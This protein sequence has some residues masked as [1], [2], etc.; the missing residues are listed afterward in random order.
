MTT[1]IIITA[2]VITTLWLLVSSFLLLR[3]IEEI[4]I[5]Q[6]F[7]WPD[8]LDWIDLT[9]ALLWPSALAWIVVQLIIYRFTNR[10]RKEDTDVHPTP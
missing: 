3:R 7:G 4:T 2:T 9:S 5:A 10:A 8:K 6:A 1:F